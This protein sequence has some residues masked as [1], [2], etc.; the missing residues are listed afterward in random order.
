MK[1]RSQQKGFSYVLRST[2]TDMYVWSCRSRN[3]GL[4]GF[5]WATLRYLKYPNIWNRYFIYFKC[6]NYWNRW[7]SFSKWRILQLKRLMVQ[8]GYTYK[9]DQVRCVSGCFG[10]EACSFLKPKIEDGLEAWFEVRSSSYCPVSHPCSDVC[11]FSQLTV[12]G[13]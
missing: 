9:L 1:I 10:W 13:T 6:Y 7:F 11:L 4:T 8:T 5:K 2:P 12:C 3:F